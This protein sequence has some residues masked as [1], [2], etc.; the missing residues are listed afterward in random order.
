MLA[1]KVTDLARVNIAIFIIFV[2]LRVVITQ[3][4]LQL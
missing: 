4:L 3:P 2:I 1:V